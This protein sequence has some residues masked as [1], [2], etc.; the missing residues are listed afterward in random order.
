M[1]GCWIQVHPISSWKIG[2]AGPGRS[3]QRQE[4]WTHTR[5]WMG[6]MTVGRNDND[7]SSTTGAIFYS[8][9]ASKMPHYPEMTACYSCTII[10]L[11]WQKN[12]SQPKNTLH[13]HIILNDRHRQFTPDDNH[14]YWLHTSRWNPACWA[15]RYDSG[16]HRALRIKR[17]HCL[18]YWKTQ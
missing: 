8:Q 6:R 18:E 12:Q 5:F 1:A 7:L 3:D 13:S 14:F 4:S 16:H 10:G 2:H 9:K 15:Y 11:G 17:P